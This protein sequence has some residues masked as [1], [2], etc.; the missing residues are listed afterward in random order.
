MIA[1]VTMK[2]QALSSRERH[3]A[4]LVAAVLLAAPW[5]RASAPRM[6]DGAGAA[7]ATEAAPEDFSDSPNSTT[8]TMPASTRP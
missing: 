4:A 8:V 1:A 3:V 5:S 6:A 2:V 7:G